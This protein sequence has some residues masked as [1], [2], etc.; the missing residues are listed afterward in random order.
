M[1]NILTITW[2][3]LREAMAR[4]VFISFFI[5]SL[6]TI[7]FVAFIISMPNFVKAFVVGAGNNFLESFTALEIMF[8]SPISL[9]GILMSVFS[10]AS[11]IPVMLEKGN[12]DLLL[13]KPI[14]RE[15]L[16]IGKYL[17]G[18][19]VVLINI[20]LLII[21]VWLVFSIKF[22]VWNFGFLLTIFTITFTFAILYSIIV[23]F[24]ILTKSSAPGMMIAYLI[25]LI[26][27]PVL[28][29]VKYKLGVLIQ[30]SL[31]KGI[32]DFV[33]YLFPKTSELMGK[34][35]YDL[36]TGGGITNY[37]PVLTSLGFLI[38]TLGIAVA[39]FRKKDF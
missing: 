21:G 27:S 37:Q 20:A 8:I 4:K 15:Q 25:F 39:I 5:I 26:V 32:V 34:T 6:L 24:G 11:F 30:S 1:K 33:Y 35:T 18:I 36:A 31:V 12:I 38:L 7:F 17:G 29:S 28:Y 10:S 19:A 9:I 13:S 3:S 22:S 23:L 2:Y 14:S 16:L